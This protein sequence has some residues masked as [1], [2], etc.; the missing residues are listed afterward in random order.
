MQREH[1]GPHGASVSELVERLSQRTDLRTAPNHDL[2]LAAAHHDIGKTGV[3]EE[4]LAAPRPLTGDERTL[5]DAHARVGADLLTTLGVD[6]EATRAVANHHER[7]DDSGREIVTEPEWAEV[8]CACDAITTMLSNRPY[9]AMKTDREALAEL[10]ACR[11]TQFHPET[12]DA[13]HF[14]D[15]RRPTAA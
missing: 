10:R 13:L 1:V 2:R 9:A 4:L 11:G 6:P 3:P 12:V 14:V 7:Y 5:V 8:I 15:I